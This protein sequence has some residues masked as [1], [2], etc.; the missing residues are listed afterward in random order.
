MAKGGGG[1]GNSSRGRGGGSGGPAKGGYIFAIS[2]VFT[3]LILI[4]GWEKLN[5]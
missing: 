4:F 3:Y 2:M 1:R 5:S